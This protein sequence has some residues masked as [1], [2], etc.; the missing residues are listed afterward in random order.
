MKFPSLI[1]LEQFLTPPHTQ[2]EMESE[3]KAIIDI[4]TSVVLQG[5]NHPQC[6]CKGL[7]CDS[8]E[9]PI[10]ASAGDT[11]ITSPLLNHGHY[12]K[13]NMPEMLQQSFGRAG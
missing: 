11:V 2:A 13:S 10:L 3:A 4:V 6:M 12:F 1:C 7:S 5:G 8:P 9:L